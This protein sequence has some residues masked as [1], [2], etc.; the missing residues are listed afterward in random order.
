M[1]RWLTIAVAFLSLASPTAAWA[2]DCADGLSADESNFSDLLS[3]LREQ[4]E[5]IK[6]IKEKPAPAGSSSDIPKGAILILDDA[7]GCPDGWRDVGLHESDRFAGRMIVA[8]GPRV[9]RAN[10]GSTLKREFNKGSGYEKIALTKEQMPKHEHQ[11]KDVFFSE[12]TSN[13]NWQRTRGHTDFTNVPN[14]I[15]LKLKEGVDQDN[16]GYQYTRDSFSTGEGVAI[17]N[18]SPYI[19][20]YFCKKS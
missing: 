13:N 1:L 10:G 19:P 3:C 14:K 7:K 5:A 17:S 8:V 11:Y 12:T 2:T 4:A 20:L 9:D 18:M 6:Q 16:S 15:G